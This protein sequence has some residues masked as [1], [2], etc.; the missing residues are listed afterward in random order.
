[1]AG[2]LAVSAVAV[3]EQVER[4]VERGLDVAGGPLG[5]LQMRLGLGDLGG[6]A[7]L[8]LAE[9]IEGNGAGVV[10]VQELL[11]LP[12]EGGEA[13]ALARGFALGLLALP[14]SAW[15][16]L[17]RIAATRSVGRRTCA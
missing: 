9:Q 14:E 6:Q 11:A 12:G 1:M 3:G 4:L 15:S 2:R 13:T 8:L 5:G 17:V 10:G 7:I 16:S